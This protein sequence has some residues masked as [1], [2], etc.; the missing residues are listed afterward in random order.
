MGYLIGL[1]IGTSGVKGILVS[2]TGDIVASRT[3]GYPLATPNP[4]WAE[5]DPEDWWQATKKVI[6][7]LL[8][9]SQIDPG[10]VRG[11][12]LSGQ[13]HSSVF[14]NDK[15]EVIRPAILWSDTRTTRQCQEIYN[16]V[17]GLESLIDLVSNPALEGFTAPKILWLRDNEPENFEEVK[18]VLLP[19]DYIRYKLTGEINT[20]VSDAAGTL[21]L[22]VVEKDW[23]KEI[24]DRLNLDRE[25][26]PPVLDSTEIAGKVL[27]GVAVETGL[28]PGTPVVAGGADNACGAVGSGIVSE[29]RVMVSVGSSGVVLAQANNP[30]ADKQG[31]IHLFNHAAPDKWY[32]MGVMLSAG[33]SFK[34]MKEK[35]FNDRLDYDKLNELADSV[36]PGCEGL[37][38]LPYLYGERTPHADANARGVYFGISGKHHQGHFIRAVMEGV[39]FGLKDSLELIKEKGVTI[40]EI[41][42]IGGGAKSRIWQQIMAD[43]FGQE[44]NLLNIEEGPAFGAA[45]I[46]G[47]GVGEY[48]NF[49]EAE[50]K[51]IK[52]RKTIEPD[53]NNVQHYN[54]LYQLYRKLY[55]SLKDDF[56][57]LSDLNN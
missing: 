54:D 1:D 19:K 43:I 56:K 39:T 38:F 52:V 21:L 20:E 42:A 51:I 22:D 2:V 13:M 10:T 35:M 55:T 11:I 24:L 23:S 25:M 47:V 33:M 17:D 48:A 14:L 6:N 57:A 32:M 26:L 36:D 50:D 9:D 34:W 46:A 53:S 8:T 16:R 28:K 5:Q 30:R 15:M 40:K 31:R 27:P 49:K 12:S 41:R 37:L 45:L 4:G 29:G 3:E 7:G 18:L 44:I